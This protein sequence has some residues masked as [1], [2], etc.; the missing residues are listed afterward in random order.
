[1][2]TKLSRIR[3]WVPRK[4]DHMGPPLPAIQKVGVLKESIISVTSL[5]TRKLIVV[6]LM[7]IQRRLVILQ[8]RFVWNL[9]LLVCP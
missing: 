5:G 7:L 3:M 1:M 9:I 8:K 4:V 2:T 6:S